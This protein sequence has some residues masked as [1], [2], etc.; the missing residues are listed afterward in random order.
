MEVD[1]GGVKLT[2]GAM[3]ILVSAGLLVAI[4]VMAARGSV[5]AIAALAVLAAVV[6]IGAG[7]AL[8]IGIHAMTTRQEQRQFVDNAREN[9]AI[10]GAMQRVQNMQ[11]QNLMRQLPA[12]PGQ[13]PAGGL[14]YDDYLFGA[15][16]EQPAMLMDGRD[17]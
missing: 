3:G 15:L 7:A 16:D 1:N 4:I 6:L 8:V 10:M 13:S 11:T 9:L 5:A 17:K 14:Q 12:G 2:A